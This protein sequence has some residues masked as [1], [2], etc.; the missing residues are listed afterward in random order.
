MTKRIA[1]HKKKIVSVMIVL[2]LLAGS[3]TVTQN[4]KESICGCKE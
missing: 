4:K 1:R 2:A 3:L